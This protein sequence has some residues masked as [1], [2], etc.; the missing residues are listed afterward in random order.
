M[1]KGVFLIFLSIGL[2]F[3][4]KAQQSTVWTNFVKAKETGQTP[5]IP[6]FSYAGYK[7]GELPIPHVSYKVFNILDFGALPNDGMSDKKALQKAIAA[8]E[9]NKGGIVYIPKGK[10]IINTKEDDTTPLTIKASN[11]VLKGEGAK[12]NGSV[13]FFEKDLPPKNPKKLWSVPYAMVT[14]CKEESSKLG[15]VTSIAERETFT[16]EIENGIKVKKGDWVTLK[17]KSNDLELVKKDLYPLSIETAWSNILENGVQINERHQITAIS[18]N[19]VTFKEPI[20]Y[21]INPKYGWELHSF[22]HLK[23][24]GFENILFMGNWK[25]DFVHHGSAKDDG[26]WSILKMKNLVDSWITNCSFKNVNRALSINSSAATTAM[27]ITIEGNKGHNAISAGGGST[28]IFMGFIDDKSG[29]HHST[30]VGGNSTTGTVIWRS[31]HPANTSFEA[32]ASQP[33]CTLLDNIEGGFFAGRAG[34]AIKNLPNHGR[35]LVLWNYKETDEPEYN[36]EFIAKDSPYW[37]IVPPIIV[38]FHGSGTTFNEREVAIVE[39][40]GKPVQ[41]ESLYEAQLKLRLGKLPDWLIAQK[42]MGF[43]YA[44]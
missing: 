25:E 24:I 10:Y 39:S 33:R 23:H 11:I 5:N 34:G 6:D 4:C 40:I 26:G 30:G 35:Y 36:F 20:R 7:Y 28:G 41:P 38:G 16:I 3:S 12:E 17:M 43:R 22:P 29:M 31:R 9:K 21:H 27:N 15:R 1:T 42:K 2:L 44:E 8:A 37:R 14:Q 13:L 32:H 18:G 19:K